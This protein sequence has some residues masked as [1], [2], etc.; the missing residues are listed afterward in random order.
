MSSQHPPTTPPP[1]ENSPSLADL[2]HKLAESDQLLTHIFDLMPVAIILTRAEDGL[3]VDVNDHYCR[4]SGF[5]RDELIG[6]TLVD[7]GLWPD[8]GQ[9]HA[10]L[11]HL[12]QHTVLSNQAR[13]FRHKSGHLRTVLQ[14]SRLLT[15]ETQ[16]F[17]ITFGI[18]IQDR[19]NAEDELRHNQ[20]KYKT[21]VENDFVGIQVIQNEQR[22]FFNQHYLSMTG[23]TATEIASI[24][25]M[26]LIH[27]DDLPQAVAAYRDVI[28][29]RTPDHRLELRFTTAAKLTRWCIAHGVR[30]NWE[31]APAVVIFMQ[32]I[33]ELRRT[34]T[35]LT[36]SETRFA[37]LFHAS[38]VAISLVS[39]ETSRIIDVNQAWET[40]TGYAA[41]NAIGTK[42]TDLDLWQNLTHRQH[43]ID[44]L[45]QHGTAP[46][47]ETQIKTATGA[48]RDILIYT[49]LLTIDGAPIAMS[50]A[51]D[52]TERNRAEQLIRQN[53][54]R[55]S[56]VF[57]GSP[58]PIA[59]TR[60]S[61]NHLVAVNPAWAAI[62]G[63]PAEQAIDHAIDEFHI[64]VNSAARRELIDKLKTHGRVERF[65]VDLYHSSGRIAN[66]L[67]SAEIITLEGQPH[68]LSLA[69]DITDI[70]RMEQ[71]LRA[72]EALYSSV[73]AALSEG[74][75][76][77]DTADHVVLANQSAATI[78][79]LPL[80]QLLGKTSYDPRWQA[81]HDDGTPFHPEEHPSIVATRTGQPVNGT[82]MNV[83]TG[84]DQQRS[85]IS[86]NAR[87]IFDEHHHP[88]GAVATFTDITARRQS[89][90]ARQR[91]TA[92]LEAGL[93]A[94][95]IAW[96]EMELPSGA[97]IFD[98]L[99]AEMIGYPPDR[100]R[101]YQ[102]FVNLVHPDDQP[103]TMQAMRNHLE[104]QADRYEVEYRLQASTGAYVWFR[105]I[106][107]I[108][109]RDSTTGFVR[110]VGLVMNITERK[111]ADE[112]IR[113]AYDATL[114]GWA[115]TLELRDE[116]TE[117]H[118]Q[119]VV[120]LTVE[121]CHA[122]GLSEEDVIQ[123]RRGA[124]LHD[125]GKMGIPDGILLKPGP[126]TDEEWQVMK[127]HPVYAYNSLS[128]IPFLQTALDIP[129][130]HHEKW[131][132]SGYPRGLKD[133]EIP[134]TARIFAIVD[135]FDALSVDR[136]YRAAWPYDRIITHLKDQSGKHFD[137][138]VVT[139]F[140]NLLSAANPELT[141]PTNGS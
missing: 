51:I 94:G 38:P 61:D 47:V 25:F 127:M 84:D 97:V 19:V 128:G 54:E 28:S 73:I 48:I 29:G 63:I 140:L 4:Q 85:I 116:E 132:G 87:P 57:T 98:S 101:T 45:R 42:T 46:N 32:D 16:E 95:D 141:T 134:L 93:K 114:E 34:A 6:R 66:L 13:Q 105:D 110:V 139:A 33:T 119:R 65:P 72:D 62:T 103:R 31:G 60:L 83:Y 135:V 133:E 37:K 50:S 36:D 124:L 86:V 88:T 76:V 104:G 11:Q 82:I 55:F 12:R 21:I 52:L 15:L 122:M 27:K 80:D 89:E 126:L 79:G 9:R 40:L 100:F 77:Q 5:A 20:H 107:A 92:R 109:E 49:D 125:I 115:K 121:L 39:V 118:A 43:I 137:P 81:L 14:F 99:K 56:T 90:E 18:D 10:W 8:A 129:Y 24:P 69:L 30:A 7:V 70:R 112:K 1:A 64:W 22:V 117:G 67:L 102:D 17:I 2:H 75:V 96:W 59:I 23:F 130:C 120:N 41:H 78:L 53:E 136:P 58:I 3:C 111:Q 71:Q 108:T 131:D 44:Q 91:L 138:R 35:R 113:S 26:S 74:L 106:G 68:M 123:S